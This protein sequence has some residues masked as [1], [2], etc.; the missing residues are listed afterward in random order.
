MIMIMIKLW[1]M[2]CNHRPR[3]GKKVIV[4]RRMLFKCIVFIMYDVC[5]AS[6]NIVIILP[7]VTKFSFYSLSM[8]VIKDVSKHV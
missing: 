6:N 7:L 2:V 3:G 1:Q 4:I 5:Q 8:I